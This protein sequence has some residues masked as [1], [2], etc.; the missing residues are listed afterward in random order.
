MTINYPDGTVLKAIV[1][2]HE[3][4]AIRA[5]AAG[6]DVMAFTRIQGTWLSE[7]IGPEWQRRPRDRR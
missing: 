4:H 1:R 2:S 6:R 5:V 3:E 7:E